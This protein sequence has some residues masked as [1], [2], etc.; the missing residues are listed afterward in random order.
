MRPNRLPVRTAAFVA[1]ALLVVSCASGR[2][3]EE[4]G[5]ADTEVAQPT[6]TVDSPT[7]DDS[8]D[9][10][11]DSAPD[12]P[13]STTQQPSDPTAVATTE[14]AAAPTSSTST[15]PNADG[16][17]AAIELLALITVQNERGAGY[18]RDLF[19]HWEDFDRDGCDTRQEVLIRDSLSPAQIDPYRCRV[20]EGDW[21]STY[22]GQSTSLPSD[23]DI[24]H[25]VA[26]KEAWD[27]GAWDWSVRARTLF[28]NDLTDR[29]SLIAVSD[30]SN[31]SKSDKDPS[32]WMP[33]RRGDW[34]RYLGD[35]VAIKVRWNLSMDPSEFGRIQNLLE[36]ECVG[37]RVVPP[38]PAPV[39]TASAGGGSGSGGTSTTSATSDVYY[40]NCTAV[41]AAGAAPLLAGEPGY[42]RALDRDGDGVACEG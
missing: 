19:P 28:A 8:G 26:L 34:C 21:F 6:S 3:R 12:A 5:V 22:D 40:A 42:R 1:A 4:T 25:V 14:Q 35:W 30:N 13:A 17:V 41:R 38:A 10:A 18:D 20:V 27:S 32:N 23:I 29:R 9:G 37:L 11:V 36:D 24:D 7:G 2:V 15:T 16:T 31:Q 33:P 39:S